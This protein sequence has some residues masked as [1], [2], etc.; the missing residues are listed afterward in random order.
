MEVIQEEIIFKIMQHQCM[1]STLDKSICSAIIKEVHNLG[2][3]LDS[4]LYSDT[5]SYSSYQKYFLPVD[6]DDDVA[7]MSYAFLITSKV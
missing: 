3:I 1:I 2:R 6:S 7:L 4:A 5:S